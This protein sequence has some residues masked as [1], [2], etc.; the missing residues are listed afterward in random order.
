MGQQS[1]RCNIYILIFFNIIMQFSIPEVTLSLV[2][3][4][5]FLPIIEQLL[6]LLLKDDTA[7]IITQFD[8]HS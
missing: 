6:L 5:M 1:C 7:Y 8:E 3:S 4:L 2:T